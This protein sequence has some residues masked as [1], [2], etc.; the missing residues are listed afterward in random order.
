VERSGADVDALNFMAFA[1]AERSLRPD[2][3]RAFAWRAV[4]RDPHSGYVTDTLGWAELK[5]GDPAAAVI[6]LRRADR[7]A[8][9]EGEIWFHIAAAEQAAGHAALSRDAADKAMR[10]LRPHDPLRARIR[11]LVAEL[12]AK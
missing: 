4:L 8:P 3:A 12:P 5:A 1:L 6:T 9:D 10:L 2:D 11:A 7:L